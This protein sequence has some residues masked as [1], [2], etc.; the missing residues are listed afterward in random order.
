MLNGDCTKTALV[1]FHNFDCSFL[2]VS[3]GLTVFYHD[4]YYQMKSRSLLFPIV[5]AE[6]KM[7]RVERGEPSVDAQMI[8][9]TFLRIV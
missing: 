8:P 3:L 6:T 2:G 4:A 5:I 9:S 1:Q 7:G